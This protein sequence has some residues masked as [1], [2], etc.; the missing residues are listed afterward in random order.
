MKSFKKLFLASIVA[1]SFT[2]GLST[3]IAETMG[4]K[5]SEVGSDIKKSTKKGVR[6]VKDKTCE[7]INGKMECAA[8]K[9]GHKIQNGVDEVK[10]KADDVKK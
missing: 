8:K 1:V 6:T 7:M 10:D 9:I 3:A 4:E 5:A 2:A